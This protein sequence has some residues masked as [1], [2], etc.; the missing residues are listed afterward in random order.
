M[1]E[2]FEYALA[3]GAIV[4]FDGEE[5]F[6]ELEYGYVL[7]DGRWID[8][9][10]KAMT[11]VEEQDE[12]GESMPFD[13]SNWNVEGEGM[14]N[15]RGQFEKA[16]EPWTEEEQ[17]ARDR[18]DAEEFA[19]AKGRVKKAAGAVESWD[20]ENVRDL[21]EALQELEEAN[22]EVDEEDRVE[23]DLQSLPTAPIPEDVD[24]SWPVWA[25]DANQVLL[26]GETADEIMTL[27]EYREHQQG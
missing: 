3:Q 14:F 19:E 22:S 27:A 8:S 16:P 1:K 17:E 4:R 23:V 5:E 15:E 26:V 11:I 9:A 6:T 20:T 21:I 12:S 13:W 25:M 18:E 7:E 24:T 10:Y 2:E